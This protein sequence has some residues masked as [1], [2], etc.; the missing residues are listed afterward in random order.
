M[1]GPR[2]EPRTVVRQADV[3]TTNTKA[4]EN[5]S[6]CNLVIHTNSND[7]N[8]TATPAYKRNQNCNVHM[9][10][11]FEMIYPVKSSMVKSSE[12]LLLFIT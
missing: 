2:I 7:K 11:I 1:P 12:N 4:V 3:L 5:D 6:L 10:K 8:I 9:S